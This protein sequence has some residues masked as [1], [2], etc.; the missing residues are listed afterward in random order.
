M[1]GEQE[2]RRSRGQPLLYKASPHESNRC[3]S[4][5]HDAGVLKAVEAGAREGAK[6]AGVEME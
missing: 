3:D 2:S 1:L 5:E 6:E 4:Q